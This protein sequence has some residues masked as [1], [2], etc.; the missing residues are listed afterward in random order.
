MQKNRAKNAEKSAPKTHSESKEEGP[1]QPFIHNGA[2]FGPKE[3]VA[4]FT[5]LF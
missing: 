2:K 4:A 1:K 3:P 5:G